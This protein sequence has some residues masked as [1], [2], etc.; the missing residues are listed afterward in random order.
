MTGARK[1]LLV[2]GLA[3]ACA[4]P[5]LCAA[6][7][8]TVKIEGMKYLPET[9][10]VQRGDKIVWQNKDMVPHTV[11][12][13][14]SFDSGNIDGGKSWSHAMKKAGRFDYVCTFHPGMKAVV[15]VE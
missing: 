14:G 15:V 5:G 6:A 1:L 13:K 2:A 4:L 9:I 12:A 11:T 8:H 3:A 7:T 10:T